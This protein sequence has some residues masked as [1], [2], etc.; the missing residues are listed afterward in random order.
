[1]SYNN[2]KNNIAN[3]DFIAVKVGDGNLSARTANLTQAQVRNA[4]EA[5]FL[6]LPE[7]LLEQG[8]TY[9]MALK[10]TVKS[11]SALQFALKINPEWGEIVGINSGDLPQFSETNYAVFAE[12]GIVSTA[13]ST[14]QAFQKEGEK[15]VFYLTI[16]AKKSGKL[17]EILSL[18]D[19]FTEGVVYDEKGDGKPLKLKF[20][21]TS[22]QLVV[23]QNYPN[24]FNNETVIPFMLPKEDMVDIKIYDVT[25]KLVKQV[26]QSFAKGY[27]EFHLNLTTPSVNGIL[28]CRFTTGA[29]TLERKM[30]LIR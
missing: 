14:T 26:N 11:F 18:K 27:N 25:G 19:D 5:E 13:W 9:K 30:I 4:P 20:S 10:T 16:K 21:T 12:K 22:D 28:I 15:S 7:M 3:A 24:P 8:N 29:Q 6:E 23:M 2:P 1:L 17:I